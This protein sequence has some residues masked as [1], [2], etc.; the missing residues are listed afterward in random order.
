MLYSV[1]ENTRAEKTLEAVQQLL[2][3]LEYGIKMSQHMNWKFCNFQL[4]ELE[5]LNLVVNFD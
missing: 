4:N 2:Q 5:H 3:V 1:F